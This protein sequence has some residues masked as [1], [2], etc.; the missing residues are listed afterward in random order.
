MWLKKRLEGGG[1]KEKGN[2]R[3]EKGNRKMEIGGWKK[4]GR[5][6]GKGIREKAWM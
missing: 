6:K 2:W 5:Y 4:R 1:K 3:L